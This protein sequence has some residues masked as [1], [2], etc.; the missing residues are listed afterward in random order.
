MITI[1]ENTFGLRDESK[2]IMPKFNEI[3]YG[4]NTFSYYG[5]HIWNLLPF[6]V[7]SAVSLTVLKKLLM[8]WDGPN[9]S[10]SSCYV[11]V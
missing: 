9:C 5:S 3:K 4:R 6:N 11:S 7:K 2:V 10:C 1:K 8:S